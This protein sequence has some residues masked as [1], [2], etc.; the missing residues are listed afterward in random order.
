MMSAQRGAATL[1]TVVILSIV[2]LMIVMSTTENT[3]MDLRISS[4]DRSSQ[5]VIQASESG[6]DYALTWLRDNNLP[7]SPNPL[8]CSSSS[9]P[10]G[11]PSL[12]TITS[13][14]TTTGETYSYTLT[15][16]AGNRSVR[17]QSEAVADSDTAITA[18]TESWVL[19]STTNL[20]KSG[21][22]MPPPWVLA[23]CVTQSPTGTPDT[24]VLDS[25]NLAVE[26]GTDCSGEDQQGNLK[27]W[28]WADDSEDGV[29]DALEVGSEITM[30]QARFDCSET[31]CSWNRYFNTS[32][33]DAKALATDYTSGFT[34]GAPTVSPSLYLFDASQPVNTGDISGSC[35]STGV[36]DKTLGTPSTPVVIIVPD[37]AGCPKFNGGIT[38]YGIVYYESTD[39]SANGWGGATVY[40]SVMWEGDV[41]KPNAN[42]EFIE[43]DYE[44]QG[45]LNSVF[46]ASVTDANRLAGTWK[47]F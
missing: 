23:G 20:F 8:V 26:N 6:L 5:E 33:T 4:N 7:A 19:Q 13:S 27:V 15:F 2:S 34:C 22:S 40:G 24:Y 39:C 17:V 18:T 14:D 41:A 10:T 29:M 36:D 38:V 16:T 30:N 21:I 46:N 44:D 35:S 45:D 25:A 3:I 32:L 28:S 43:V 1:V 11:C 37:S 9:A 42:S 31:E 12:T 47:D